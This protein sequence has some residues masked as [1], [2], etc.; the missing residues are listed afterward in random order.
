MTGSSPGKGIDD[1]CR[2]ECERH[3]Q[4]LLPLTTAADVQMLK[5]MVSRSTSDV[6]LVTGAQE[7]I[8][9]MGRVLLGRPFG[10][11]VPAGVTIQQRYDRTAPSSVKG[12]LEREKRCIGHHWGFIYSFHCHIGV[13]AFGSTANCACK[14]EGEKFCLKRFVF[15]RVPLLLKFSEKRFLKLFFFCFILLENATGF[16]LFNN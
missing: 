15:V 5:S 3:H 16:F 14:L 13:S 6:I 8:D 12:V 7:R 2:R 9:T 10:M 1:I 4:I 11:P